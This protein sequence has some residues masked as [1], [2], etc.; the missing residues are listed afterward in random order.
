MCDFCFSLSTRRSGRT[1][2]LRGQN[3]WL[4]YGMRHELSLIPGARTLA[5]HHSQVMSSEGKERHRVCC[6]CR[7]FICAAICGI[8]NYYQSPL[9]VHLRCKVVCFRVCFPWASF[10]FFSRS[11]YV[12]S[13]R[14]E[15]Y[16]L[17]VCRVGQK[18]RLGFKRNENS[19]IMVT[20]LY[21]VHQTDL[22]RCARNQVDAGL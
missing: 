1:R 17:L 22:H 20:R 14:N 9:W 11:T 5:S 13:R 19:I 7:W 6:A 4:D 18:H 16:L 15:R 3:W 8:D 10:R 2:L 21:G 12:R